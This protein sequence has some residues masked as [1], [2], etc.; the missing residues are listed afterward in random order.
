M[1]YDKTTH[2]FLGDLCNGEPPSRKTL[3]AASSTGALGNFDP[4]T[5][6]FLLR[7]LTVTSLAFLSVAVLDFAF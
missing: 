6:I 5:T 4:L 2:F 1:F 3:L 7:T